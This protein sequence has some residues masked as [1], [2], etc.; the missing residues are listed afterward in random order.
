MSS[1]RARP[2]GLTERE[3]EVL[4][5]MAAG[6]TDREIA[7]ALVVN[8]GPG[9]KHVSNILTKTNVANRAKGTTYASHQR[10]T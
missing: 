2:V 10:L 9:R 6:K 8:F 3:A 5:R 1:R 7:E 4:R